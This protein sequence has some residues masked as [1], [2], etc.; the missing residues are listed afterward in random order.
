MPDDALG[1][2][3]PEPVP[4]FENE[5]MPPLPTAAMEHAIARMNAQIDRLFDREVTQHNWSGAAMVAAESA[6]LASALARLGM[7][8]VAGRRTVIAARAA[9]AKK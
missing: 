8:Q 4:A 3:T 7:V 2:I 1:V 6:R 9:R 5:R